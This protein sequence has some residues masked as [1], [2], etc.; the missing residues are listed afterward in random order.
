MRP[1][2][3]LSTY[4]WTILANKT[5]Q[6]KGKAPIPLFYIWKHAGC[7]TLICLLLLLG[8]SFKQFHG[9]QI[10]GIWININNF[11]FFPLKD[12]YFIVWKA[13][14]VFLSNN[15]R[16]F[17]DCAKSVVGQLSFCLLFWSCRPFNKPYRYDVKKCQNKRDAF[18]ALQEWKRDSL[19]LEGHRVLLGVEFYCP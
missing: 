12:R 3:F 4:F 13:F 11:A 6:K 10:G 18:Q 15:L 14:I 8:V 5:N 7:N 16:T 17:E 1:V 19:R 9:V 2:L